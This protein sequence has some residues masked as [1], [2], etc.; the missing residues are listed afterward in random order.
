[1]E[2]EIAIIVA[3]SENNVIAKDGKIPWHIPEDM[4]RFRDLTIP[5]PVIMGRKTYESLPAK[6]KPLP[7]RTNIVVTR[8]PTYKQEN[9]IVVNDVKTA[10][11]T[12]RNL[13]NLSFVIG[14][15][16]IYQQSLIYAT[17]MYL[18]RIHQKIEGEDL[19]FFPEINLEEW[20]ETNRIDKEDYSFIDYKRLYW[21]C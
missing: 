13:D 2:K 11:E 14:G 16:E 8:D 21:Y 12:A 6:F 3:L 10:L 4:S 1:M 7:Q 5:H 9:I 20:E 19:T 15:G 17:K 18:T